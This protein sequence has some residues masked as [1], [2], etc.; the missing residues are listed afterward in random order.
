M[1]N[2]LPYY[3]TKGVKIVQH[4]FFRFLD[5]EVKE[6]NGSQGNGSQGKGSNGNRNDLF[7]ILSNEVSVDS[8]P[9]CLMLCRMLQILDPISLAPLAGCEL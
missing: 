1:H 8:H 3:C 6:A 4:F 7:E 2:Y 9:L 5:V